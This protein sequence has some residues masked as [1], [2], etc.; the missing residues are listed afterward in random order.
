MYKTLTIFTI[1]LS[2]L[3]LQGNAQ[4]R[5]GYV[6][7]LYQFM[8]QPDKTDYSREFYQQN[9]ALS[10]KA[11]A[12]MPWGKTIP[13]RE[14]RHFVVPV[15]VN[16]ENL[17]NSREVFY[18]ALK[19]RVEKLS[20]QEA[21][22]EVNH[23][24]HEHVTYRPSDGRTSSPLA[25]LRTAY[26]RCGEQSTF[27]VAALRAVGIPARQVYT[28]RW[29][30]TDDNHAWV[31]A[32]AD[33]K[34]YF[35]GACEPE[36]VLN[37]GWFN[38]SASRGMLMH[39]KAFGNYDGPEEVMSVTPCYTEINV[40][41]NYAP[42]AQINVQ[43]VNAKGK[44][45]SGARVEFK[46]YNYAEFYTVANKT[47]DKLGHASLTAGKGDMLLWVSKGGLVATRKVSFGKD[48]QVKIVLN[49]KELPDLV[50]L[51]IVP[52]PVSAQLPLVTPEQRAENNRRSAY[53]DSIRHA[54]EATMPVEDWRGN[55][56]TIQ[57]FLDEAPNKLMA[58]KL[59]GVL[60]KKDLR[61]IELAVL[62]DNQVAAVDTSDIYLKYV[63]C[64]RVELEWLTPYKAFFRKHMA[65]IKNPSQLE[66]WCNKNIRIDN[67][68]NPQ[69]LRM[70]P[71][72]VYREKL[73]DDLGRN[74]F[75][76]SVARSL[77]MPARINEVN[78]K[79]QYY[80]D[81]R[82]VDVFAKAQNAKQANTAKLKLD[83]KLSAHNDNPKYY[84][85]FTLSKVVDGQLQLQTFPEEATQQDFVNGQELDKGEYILTTG[86]RMASG[87][88]LARM[89][90]FTLNGD[91]TISYA[92][93]EN[94]EDVQVIG[95]LNA[96]DIYHDKATDSD[97]SLL[98]TTGRGYYVLAIVAPNQ[99]P[100]NH[101]MRDISVY[102][103]QFEEWGRKMIFLFQNDDEA[104]RF[105][106]A[107]FDKLP[108]TVVW[109]TDVEGKIKQE[110]WQQM[111]LTTPSL[112]VFLIC[113]SFNRVVFVQQGYTINLGEQLIKVIRQL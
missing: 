59:L 42:T 33:G 15:R 13:E 3:C 16:N 17:D 12:E 96:E 106:F 102:K 8:P 22:L 66:A 113:D 64:P 52:P 24:C 95:S 78:G 90:R 36:P 31:E 26:G 73:T 72:S 2:S 110:V 44:P 93:R 14:F 107:E 7:F 108:N 94:Q 56:R 29:A 1:L 50:D 35:L 103:Q 100:T 112:P 10:L 11:R 41:D 5:D 99:E 92:L 83:Y 18:K 62:K 69:G 79:P 30:H 49:S 45:V 27:T 71:M 85:H 57:Q 6:D 32:W 39:T 104:Q 98:S 47:T 54:Y 70:Q 81:G 65:D 40:I 97:K 76:V 111:K 51:D 9:V 105:N 37:L 25:T 63:L 68:H 43:V 23:W 53:E 34:W 38:E 74:I 77:D 46:L 21:I 91:T 67:D 28:P 84:I 86:V 109:G 58:E 55:H 61:D 48:K 89:Q 75:F 88:V 82:W 19:P 20:M 101:A 60:A 4:T 87:K 80:A